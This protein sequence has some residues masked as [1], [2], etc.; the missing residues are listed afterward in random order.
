MSLK[1]LYAIQGTGNGHVSRAFDVI[2]ALEK[3]GSVDVLISGNQSEVKLPFAI[4]YRLKGLGF[5]FG[6][7]GGVDI[8][9]SIKQ[10]KPITFFNEIRQLPVHQYDIVISDFEPV[11]AWA[12]RWH[13]KP[14]L[15]LSHQAAVIRGG[16]PKTSKRD[17][18]GRLIL[19]N[20]CPTSI[21]WGFHFARFDEFTFTPIIREQIRKV[22]ISEGNHYTVYLPAYADDHIVQV[23]GH[24]P[25]TEW[26]VFSKKCKVATQIG[27]IKLLPI[28]ADAFVTSL[29]S[30]KGV[31]TGAGFETPAEAIYLGK[32]ILA[33]PM[34]NQYEQHLNAAGLATLGVSVLSHFDQ[35]QIGIIKEWIQDSKPIHIDYPDATQQIID[36]VIAQF[37]ER[38][39]SNRRK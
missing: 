39:P 1:I 29:A 13:N 28:H 35:N 37:R 8:W 12:C 27:Q 2:P 19:E 21:A 22:S 32:K 6:Q 36:L 7:K 33:I 23:L 14:C 34:S 18:L 15:G 4:K 38:F 31:I 10:A 5:V 20:Y 30:C 3:H 24:F 17:L 9:Q 25:E 26:Q 11:S 16:A